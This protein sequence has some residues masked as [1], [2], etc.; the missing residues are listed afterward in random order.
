M[1]MAPAR[2]KKTSMDGGSYLLDQGSYLDVPRPM[3]MAPRPQ[4][5]MA[6]APAPAAPPQASGGLPGWAIALICIGVAI[7]LIVGLYIFWYRGMR[8]SAGTKRS[9]GTSRGRLPINPE[10][11]EDDEIEEEV[12]STER[13]AAETVQRRTAQGDPNF[14]PL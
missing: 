2:Y 8:P 12:V 4:T 7:V 3:P 5:F 11:D 10:Q 14:A 13:P 9:G 6:Q 1:E